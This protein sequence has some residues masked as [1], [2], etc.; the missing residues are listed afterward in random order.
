M[1]LDCL[2]DRVLWD[3]DWEMEEQLD[4]DPDTS[5]RLK[6]ELGIEEDYFVAI[7]PDPNDEEAE[8]LWDELR[9]LT[10]DAR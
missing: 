4:A 8:R 10:S 2:E 7:P 1:L 3:N 6:Q 5:R 9:E